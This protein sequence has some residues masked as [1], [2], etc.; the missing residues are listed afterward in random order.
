MQRL[1]P[2]EEWEHVGGAATLS[3][4]TWL[5]VLASASCL[6]VAALAL[7]SGPVSRLRL[8]LGLLAVDQFA[9]NV[10][11][12]SLALSGD[13]RYRWVSTIAS[14]LFVPLALHFVLRFVGAWRHAW[15]RVLL[16][17]LY[18]VFCAKSLYAFAD[19]LG[20]HSNLVSDIRSRFRTSTYF[21]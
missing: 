3:L 19:F 4:W 15:A 12:V 6:V 17:S 8:P 2:S 21:S 1:H 7:W 9:W 11:S 10:S 16:W 5:D 13:V 14:P 18:A 20:P